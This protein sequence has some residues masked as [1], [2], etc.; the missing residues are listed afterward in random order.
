MI[1]RRIKRMAEWMNNSEI[2]LN[3]RM[4]YLIIYCG[5]EDVV[6]EF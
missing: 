4:L 5:L 2:E 6:I 3:V 1:R